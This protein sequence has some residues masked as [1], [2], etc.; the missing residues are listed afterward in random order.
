MIQPKSLH[1]SRTVSNFYGTEIEIWAGIGP[2][3]SNE[4][5]IGANY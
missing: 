1:I 5:K 4:K 3:G 2:F